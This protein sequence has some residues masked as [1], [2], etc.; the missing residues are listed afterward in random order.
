M[1]I[2]NN[3]FATPAAPA[4]TPPKPKMVAM[5]AMTKKIIVKR[6]IKKIFSLLIFFSF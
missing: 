6:N 4:A 1:K 2:K 3:T 5:T